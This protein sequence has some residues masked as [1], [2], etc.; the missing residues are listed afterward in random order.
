MYVCEE[1]HYVSISPF[2]Y[3]FLGAGGGGGTSSLKNLPLCRLQ[4]V[5]GRGFLKDKSRDKRKVEKDRYSLLTDYAK[6]SFVFG[7]WLGLGLGLGLW[8]RS[9]KMINKEREK[10]RIGRTR[11]STQK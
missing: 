3:L 8:F 5:R 11:R 2:A 6:H 9:Q 7:W 4:H 10:G 1:D